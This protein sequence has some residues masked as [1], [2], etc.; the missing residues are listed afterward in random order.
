MEKSE[1][2]NK[3]IKRAHIIVNTVALAGLLLIIAFAVYAL[4]DSEQLYKAADKTNYT[5]YKP[6]IINEGKPFK[7]LQTENPDV[8]AWLSVYGTSIDYPVTQGQD[9]KKY[10]DTNA[11]GRYSLTGAIFLDAS[12]SKDFSDFNSILYGH[13]MDRH[14]MFGD[15]GKFSDRK[16]FDTYRYG[17]LY[18]GGKDHGVEFFAFLHVDA[19]DNMIFVP[20][21][22]GNNRQKYLNELYSKAMYLRDIKISANDRIVLLCT[23][24]SSST[25]GRDI[26]VGKIT[27]EVYEDQFGAGA[28]GGNGQRNVSVLGT[29][30]KISPQWFTLILILALLLTL[31]LLLEYRSRKQK[32]T[33]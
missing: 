28:D 11:E 15:I 14:A 18:Y 30:F 7:V 19:Y 29:D 21:I 32:K 13:H 25:N 9:N 10:V 3:T 20:G 8:I 1:V 16:V 2:G 17:N 24:S 27:D 31:L 22:G 26:L 12:N 4:W 33:I 6:T 5:V 23:C